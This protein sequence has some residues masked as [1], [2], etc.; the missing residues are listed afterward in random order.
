MISPMFPNTDDS[1]V[2]SELGESSF[3]TFDAADVRSLDT[4]DE[5]DLE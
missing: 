2:A 3:F 1:A 4:A 5:G